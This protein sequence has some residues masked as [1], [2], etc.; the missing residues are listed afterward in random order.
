MC[1]ITIVVSM[2]T[3]NAPCVPHSYS[4]VNVHKDASWWGLIIVL[5][6][7]PRWDLIV[8]VM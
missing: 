7:A 1:P 4:D 5:M 3:R 8:I 2:Y 6:D